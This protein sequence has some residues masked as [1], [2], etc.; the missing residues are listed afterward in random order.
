MVEH[1]GCVGCKHD[2]LTIYDL[3]CSHCKGTVV[4]SDPYHEKTTDFYEPEEVENP[5][6]ERICK[7]AD[8]QRAKGMETYG[9]GLEMN[10][11]S[12]SERLTYLQEE[13]I[14]A[15][16]YCEHIRAWI[17]EMK[18]EKHDKD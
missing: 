4:V 18:G 1:D 8:N 16:M 6:W 5:Y 17:D 12:I 15:L 13:L 11:M 7:L 14:D 2:S 9:Q 10:H 3:P